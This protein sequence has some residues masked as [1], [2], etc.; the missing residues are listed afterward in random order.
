M[1]AL[2]TFSR[3]ARFLRPGRKTLGSVV[4]IAAVIVTVHGIEMLRAQRAWAD[5][6]AQAEARGVTFSL[7]ELLPDS[8]VPAAENFATIP[9]ID[10]AVQARRG[11]IPQPTD[12]DL[13][14]GVPEVTPD[15]AQPCD[16]GQLRKAFVAADWTPEDPAASDA[17]VALRGLSRFDPVFAQLEEGAQRRYARYSRDL[18]HPEH[19]GAP[20]F[21]LLRKAAQVLHLR[22]QAHAA[23]GDME[24]AC[25]DFELSLQLARTLEESPTL[26]GGMT[27]VSMTQLTVSNLRLWLHRAPWTEAHLAR[28]ATGMRGC[29]LLLVY[30]RAMAIERAFVTH[31]GVA[32]AAGKLDPMHILFFSKLTFAETVGAGELQ[33][34]AA[35]MLWKLYP[36]GWH[37][38]SVVWSNEK[39]FDRHDS[40][41]DVAQHR[42]S[43]IGG[44][45]DFDAQFSGGQFERLQLAL[46]YIATPNLL[47]AE[48]RT[49]SVQAQV[50]LA[51]TALALEQYQRSHG[52]YP[53]Q[54]ADLGPTVT[55]T[56]PNDLTTGAPLRYRATPDGRFQLYSLS[57]NRTDD[58]GS[59][60]PDS[61]A[62][63]IGGLAHT[64]D[65]VWPQP[66]EPVVDAAP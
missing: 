35:R 25:S 32:A 59:T 20:P 66:T 21:P 62:P 23:A 52:A 46:A 42:W 24:A 49:I 31:H 41:I 17:V 54:L 60:E 47:R 1:N 5:Y 4:A 57:Y 18:E 7:A 9:I 51:R 65:W 43:P 40:R 2:P 12:L 34:S 63:Q 28:F 45:D 19:T 14:P 29:D 48:A 44:D 36:R 53:A 37:L 33:K 56:L 10:A 8:D 16:L 13:P 11:E 15:G 50:D 22:F 55:G 27:K 30:S 58:G 64:L 6:R 61:S 26:V 38:R 39:C 3:I